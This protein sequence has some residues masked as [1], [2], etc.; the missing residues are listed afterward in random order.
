MGQKSVVEVKCPYTGRYDKIKAGQFE[1]VA[2]QQADKVI[3]IISHFKRGGDVE[4]MM[5]W[6]HTLEGLVMVHGALVHP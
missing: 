1:K 4:V 6:Y 2:L 3:F 5:L